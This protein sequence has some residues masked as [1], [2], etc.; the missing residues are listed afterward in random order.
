MTASRACLVAIWFMCLCLS[1]VSVHA[2]AMPGEY[3]YAAAGMHGELILGKAAGHGFTL[4]IQ[5]GSER[6]STCEFL[7]ECQEGGGGVLICQNGNADNAA[8]R[9]T[10]RQRSESVLHVENT[11]PPSM[12]CGNG[13]GLDGTYERVSSGG[14]APATASSAAAEL[15]PGF[16]ACMETSSSTYDMLQCL[17]NA[18]THWDARLNANYKK[19]KRQCASKEDQER[20]LKAQR[21]WLKYKEA[22]Q[23][24][25]INSGEGSMKRLDSLSFAVDVTKMQAKELESAE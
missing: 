24:Y 7:G 3:V 10:V 18:Y 25:I 15:A 11:Y 22:M 4:S 20:L 14:A 1:A 5:T 19:A 21:A 23:E 16:N 13:C 8:Q 9:I 2:A 17:S 12:L 6:G